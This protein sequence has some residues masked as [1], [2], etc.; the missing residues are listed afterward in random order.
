MFLYNFLK[1]NGKK[2]DFNLGQSTKEGMD[3]TRVMYTVSQ[4]GQKYSTYIHKLYI[5][6]TSIWAKLEREETR[7][8]GSGEVIEIAD[9]WENCTNENR[10][11][12]ITALLWNIWLERN[13]RIISSKS[14]SHVCIL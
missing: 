4:S 2:C 6:T 12:L 7:G 10:G 14:T 5:H 1:Y 8:K 9:I 13:N 11:T 3:W